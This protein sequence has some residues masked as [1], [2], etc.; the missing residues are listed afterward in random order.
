MFIKEFFFRPRQS[1]DE[2]VQGMTVK[3]IITEKWAKVLCNANDKSKIFPDT[4][5]F[6]KKV[7]YETKPGMYIIISE[8]YDLAIQLNCVTEM[9]Y[10]VLNV[11]LMDMSLPVQGY[12]DALWTIPS[13]PHYV[14]F[15]DLKLNVLI[16][17]C[18]GLVSDIEFNKHKNQMLNLQLKTSV[19]LDR[20]LGILN[21]S[22]LILGYWVLA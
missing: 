10:T 12:M 15:K 4:K 7:L 14:N 18:S 11:K 3:T 13:A 21:V 19:C 22:D 17:K 8:L 5:A 1:I 6:K 9:L 16:Q 20:I 2:I